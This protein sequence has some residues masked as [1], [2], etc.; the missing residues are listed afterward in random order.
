MVCP[1]QSFEPESTRIVA[2]IR[3]IPE[4]FRVTAYLL[5]NNTQFQTFPEQIVG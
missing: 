2:K 3:P 4:N 1:W 5:L